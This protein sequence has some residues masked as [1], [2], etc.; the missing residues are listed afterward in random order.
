MFK[1]SD[2][3]SAASQQWKNQTRDKRKMN[4]LTNTIKVG[5]EM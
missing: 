1:G 2:A 5:I 3:V 4:E